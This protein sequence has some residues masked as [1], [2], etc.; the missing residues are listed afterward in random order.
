[1]KFL[2]RS[3]LAMVAAVASAFA[4]PLSESSSRFVR[5]QSAS[6]IKWHHWDEKVLAEARAAGRPVYV[7]VGS[8]LSELSRATCRQTFMQEEAAALLNQ[9]FV[10]IFVD[11]DEQPDLAAAIQFY[12]NNEK[13]AS[14]WPAHVWFTPEMQPFEGAAY[15]PPTEEWGKPGFLKVA[16]QA[17]DA[18]TRDPAG[19]R[20][21]AAQSIESLERPF[22]LASFGD[23][24]EAGDAAEALSGAIEGVLASFDPETAAFGETPRTPDAELLRALL[25]RD[26]SSDAPALASLRAMA[27]SALRDPLDGGFFRN[28]VDARWHLPTFQKTLIDQ[29]RLALAYLDAARA[30]GDATYAEPARGALDFT[31]NFLAAENGGF[32]AAQ[33]GTGEAHAGYFLWTA[34]E[35]DISLGSDAA[36]FRTVHGVEAAGNI[37]EENDPGATLKGR[38]IL[39]A[40]WPTS[41]ALQASAAKLL[42]LRLQRAALPA[43]S[44]ATAGAQGVLLA[45]LARA[46]EQLDEPRYRD[47]ARRLHAFLQKEILLPSGELRRWAGS[48]AIA[49]PVDYAAVALGFREWSRVSRDAK[50]AAMA[51]GVLAHL[52]ATYLDR[53]HGRFYASAEKLRPGVFLRAPAVGEPLLAES[54][55][56]LAG[57]SGET[58]EALRRG[59]VALL[60]DP[61]VS[62]A[63]DVLLS[64]TP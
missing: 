37:S 3:I 25:R 49:S 2:T 60:A 52:T 46:G 33:D 7:F 12:L 31:L 15:L 64:L 48:S 22:E 42:K 26:P 11:R 57:V 40:A 16:Q 20:A 36:A 56:L 35:I 55:A 58:A 32:L 54:L 5:E 28:T 1:M 50:A 14:G 63:G 53:D 34:Q 61:S 38:N 30:T 59:Q 6:P 23:E 51:D 62:V 24:P 19:A 27:R 39:R 41:P 10:S 8:E 43:G 29:A 45:T 18:W 13:Q 44:P 17:V 21:R 47:A 9:H 4:A